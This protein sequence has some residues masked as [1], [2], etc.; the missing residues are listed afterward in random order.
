MAATALAFVPAAPSGATFPGNNGRIVFASGEF[1]AEDVYV[2]AADGSGLT[3][4]T[5]TT[6][7]DHYPVWSPDGTSL[8][9]SSWRRGHPKDLPDEPRRRGSGP[10]DKTLH[11][12]GPGMR[13]LLNSFLVA[14]GRSDCVGWRPDGDFEIFTMDSRRQRHPAHQYTAH[15]FEPSWSPDGTKLAFYSNVDGDFDIWALDPNGGLDPAHQRTRVD[16]APAWSPDGTKLAFQSNRDGDFEI[17]TMNAGGARCPAHTE[18]DSTASPIGGPS[19]P[20]AAVH[21]STHTDR[22]RQPQ[23]RRDPREQVPS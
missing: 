12:L 20:V 6:G 4:L 16:S 1:G 19:S 14:R 17:Y 22:A 2:M 3:R 15:E 5:D 13:S 7:S 9:F 18:H 21:D 11:R 10:G 23:R 8:L